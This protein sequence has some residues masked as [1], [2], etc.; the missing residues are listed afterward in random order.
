MKWKQKLSELGLTETTASKSIKSKIKDFYT[1]DS[2]IARL[3]ESLQNPSDDDDVDEMES[4]LNEY[5]ESIGI[6]DEDIYNAL[7]DYD[8]N[9][10][11]NAERVR[12]MQEGKAR[13]AAQG[14]QVAQPKAHTPA[15]PAQKPASPAQNPAPVVKTDANNEGEGEKKK[16]SFGWMAFTLL[17]GV[18]TLGAWWTMKKDD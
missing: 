5:E 9:R 6:L 12:K 13:K 7:V 17:A 1:L 11:A 18:V 2:E 4:E 10:D 8:R 3:K 14:G 15:S 16:S